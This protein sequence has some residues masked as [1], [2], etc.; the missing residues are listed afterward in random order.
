MYR[1]YDKNYSNVNFPVLILAP[2]GRCGTTVLQ[3]WLSTHPDV[4]IW[5]EP[6][7]MRTIS[8]FILN[9]L[10]QYPPYVQNS[11]RRFEEKGLMGWIP[12]LHP[13]IEKVD[14][15]GLLRS[16]FENFYKPTTK[17]WGFKEILVDSEYFKLLQ[18]IFPDAKIIVPFRNLQR[19]KQSFEKYRKWWSEDSWSRW[20]TTY[21]DL[22]RYLN[23]NDFPNCLI[24]KD[25]DRE[26]NSLHIRLKDFLGI[27]LDSKFLEIKITNDES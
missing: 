18:Q 2:C 5:G 7:I 17:Y 8:R 12:N 24:I 14:K 4:W 22:H 20:E 11:N 19:I 25:I 27:N 10:K 15:F 21:H 3:R 6:H 16:M 9:Q 26:L 1:H 13:P 23:Q